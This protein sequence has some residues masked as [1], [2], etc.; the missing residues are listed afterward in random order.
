MGRIIAIICIVVL[1]FAGIWAWHNYHASGT[2]NGD[3]HRDAAMENGTTTMEN[4]QNVGE[5]KPTPSRS[6][7]PGTIN[8]EPSTGT[9][10]DTGIQTER[11][12][13][14]PN[15]PNGAGSNTTGTQSSGAPNAPQISYAPN[16]P[17]YPPPASDSQTANSPNGMRFSGTGQFQWYRQGN[18][19]Y[20]VNTQTGS[21]CVIYATLEEWRKPTVYQNGCRAS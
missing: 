4:G 2:F 8:T 11:V 12:T 18:L 20:R 6:D 15:G 13:Q 1:I 19:T 7:A 10:A 5:V 21:S 17:T 3:V 9:A 14:D 16:A